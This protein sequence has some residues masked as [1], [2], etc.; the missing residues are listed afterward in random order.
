MKLKEARE[1][2]GLTLWDM[3]DKLCVSKTTY[4]TWE[5]TNKPL[6][7][8]WQRKLTEI[9]GVGVEFKAAI[10]RKKIVTSQQAYLQ[11]YQT[12]LAC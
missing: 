9:L 2:K 12:P 11:Q 3:C 4:A 10:K 7:I 5:R 1:A 8:K 6:K